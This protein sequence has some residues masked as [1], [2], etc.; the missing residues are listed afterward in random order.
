MKQL[1]VLLNSR[2][3]HTKFRS[4]H[5]CII[6]LAVSLCGFTIQAS[7]KEEKEDEDE[8]AF[9]IA[10]LPDTQCYS[11]TVFGGNNDMF[12]AQTT[13]IKN[14]WKQ[15]NIKYVIHLGDIVQSG[16]KKP[17]EWQNAIKAMYLLEKPE[18]GLP[19]G[20]P[21][22]LTVG[23]HDQDPG[24][25]P[26]T[27]KTTSYNKYFGLEHFKD[28]PWHGGHYSNEM[29]THFD[30]ISAGGLDLIIV[31]VEYDM[32]DE[33]QENRN[34]WVLNT[35]QKY[36]DRKAIIVSHAVVQTN[37]KMGTN[38]K[39]FPDFSKQAERLYARIKFCPNLFLMLGGHVGGNSGEG[40][41]Q[42]FYN[43]S[44]VKSMLSDYQGRPKGGE[45]LMRLLKFSVKNDRISVKTFTPYSNREEGDGDSRFT[46]PLFINTNASRL[47]DFNNDGHS[48]IMW[49]NKG[50]WKLNKGATVQYGQEG[51]IPVPADYNGDGQADIAVFRPS[52]GKFFIQG[53]DT[54][55]LGQQGDIPA[56]GD[57][58]GDGF[59]E[60]AVFRPSTAT[61]YINGLPE[62]QF[63]NKN[64]IPVPGDYDGD[65]KT[66][67]AVYLPRKVIQVA[68]L[69][70]G[71][72]T[73]L[74]DVT[75]LVV[76]VPADYNG[77]G[78]TD[79]AVFRPAPGEWTIIMGKDKKVLKRV[80]PGDIPVPG[81]YGKS[82]VTTPAVYRNGQVIL[83]DGT[84][85]NCDAVPAG[86]ELVNLAY[87]IRSLMKN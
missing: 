84:R 34:I 76:P 23:N 19:Y 5:L 6:I 14:N 25:L 36:K 46:L 80:Q 74:T 35:L 21:Y 62:D 85:I 72:F 26:L 9:T 47:Y 54:I 59:A 16:E 33:D 24:Q 27:G 49:F 15:E 11:G 60:V 50:S 52:A 63:G 43:G 73:E 69:G 71:N 20:V 41:R 32:L 29:D 2:L 56:P 86:Y 1:F 81:N 77:D 82:K 55:T 61:M 7:L 30:L 58:D 42:D 48:D 65:G 40:Y 39:G 66:D 28:K 17:E 57:Y 31:Y 70:N 87:G 51:D 45:G 4:L 64:A 8:T 12:I 13:W 75:D 22:G 10:V 37:K 44:G 3:F 68:M 18:P 83:M 38:E 78:K 67:V 79:M 53:K